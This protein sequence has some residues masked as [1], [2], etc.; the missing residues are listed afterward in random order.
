MGA[1]GGGQ[2]EN[3]IARD[4]AKGN[5]RK[6]DGKGLGNAWIDMYGDIEQKEVEGQA[7]PADV[8]QK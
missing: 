8:P 4:K 2:V 7:Q 1:D 6:Q 3:S 5:D